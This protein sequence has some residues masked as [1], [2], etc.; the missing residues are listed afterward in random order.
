MHGT[1]NGLESSWDSPGLGE[2]SVEFSALPTVGERFNCMNYLGPFS[3][4]TVTDAKR[5]SD[6]EIR[7]RTKRSTY[8]LTIEREL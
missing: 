4:G 5:F 2:Q 1:L 6:T 8:V 7:F 3:T